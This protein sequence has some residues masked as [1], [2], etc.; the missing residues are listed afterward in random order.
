MSLFHN[1]EL[2]SRRAETARAV[3]LEF[4]LPESAREAF[5][6]APGQHV[7]LRAT[8][9]GADLRRTYSVHEHSADAFRICVRSDG[10][11]RMSGWLAKAQPGQRIQVMPPTGRFS[12]P[13]GEPGGRLL[14]IT[15]GIGITPV[16]ALLREALISRPD[17]RVTLLY[18]NRSTGTTVFAEELQALKDRFPQR[19]GLHFFMSRE[20]Q[21]IAL[22]DGRLDGARIGDLARTAFDPRALTAVYLCAPEAL[23]QEASRALQGLGVESSRIHLEHFVKAAAAQSATSGPVH[24]TAAAASPASPATVPA[25]GITRVTVRMDG[26]VRSFEMPRAG[27]VSVLEAAEAAGLDLPYACKGG[28]CS[29]CRSHLLRGQANMMQNYALE[30]SEVAAG[31]ILTCQ[32]IPASDEIEL[33]YDTG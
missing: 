9:D 14:F 22:Y 21:D 26:R 23:M 15:A 33:D 24:A 32:A 3:V 10:A 17:C 29:T 7:V 8:I 16:L 19:L 12:L 31:Y 4:A 2:R 20:P 13:A 28:V 27:T 18:G 1:L 25:E 6:G 5:R 30:E 11:G